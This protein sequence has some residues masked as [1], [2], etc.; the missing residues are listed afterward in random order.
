[1]DVAVSFVDFC[2]GGEEPSAFSDT[3]G[4][5]ATAEA[6]GSV[7]SSTPAIAEV[8][9]AAGARAGPTVRWNSTSGPGLARHDGRHSGASNTTPGAASVQNV[10]PTRNTADD[11]ET[12]QET[13]TES[14]DTVAGEVV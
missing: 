8:T 5:N 11:S 3:P 10:E 6:A 4:S 9:V 13:G 1:M 12:Q 7:V 2:I 14:A